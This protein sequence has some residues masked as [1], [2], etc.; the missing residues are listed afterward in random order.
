MAFLQSLNDY[1][2]E[3]E[4]LEKHPERWPYRSSAKEKLK[5]RHRATLGESQEFNR[6]VDLDF[7]RRE[8]A[9]TLKDPSVK[10]D[11]VG[12]IREELIRI[13]GEVAALKEPVKARMADTTLYNPSE[14][15]ETLAAIGLL[16]LGVDAL[17]SAA[18]SSRTT[19]I[20]GHTLTNHG[21]FSTL[22]TPSGRT[23]RCAYAS[24][25]EDESR[26]EC[27]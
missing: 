14:D 23:Y 24:I 8:L 27:D 3:I 19:T 9:I 11:R 16:S 4:Q 26:L 7:T 5:T 22:T 20:A 18:G 10:P 6:L 15:I 13:D 17:S 1:H 12:E 21:D 2:R 25:G